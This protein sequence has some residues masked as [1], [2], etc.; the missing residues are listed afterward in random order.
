[1]SFKKMGL[2]VIACLAITAVAASAAQ[3]NWFVNGV[4][5]SGSSTV[6]V[7][8]SESFTLKSKLLTREVILHASGLAC[9]TTGG[10]TIDTNHHNGSTGALKFEGVTVEKPAHCE[11]AGGTLTTTPLFDEVVEKTVS[12][13]TNTFD[14]FF[15]QSGTNFVTV[16]FAGSE[17][18]LKG[19]SAEIKGEVYGESNSFGTAAVNQPLKFNTA[20]NGISTL[21]LG[22]EAATL[23]GAATNTLTS[24][25]SFDATK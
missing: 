24:E 10:C 2:A 1:M 25:L 16:T 5:L 19:D 7:K 17:C 20:S 4:E 23:T 6:T 9:A 14:K 21:K 11:I 12:G 13:S 8:A 3:A 18:A 15:P 22:T